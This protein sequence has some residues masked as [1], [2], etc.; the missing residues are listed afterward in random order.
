MCRSNFLHHVPSQ[1]P[2][3]ATLHDELQERIIDNKGEV[4]IGECEE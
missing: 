4:G 2:K 1:R 3:C